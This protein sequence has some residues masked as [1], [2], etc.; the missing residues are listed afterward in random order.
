YTTQ[1]SE[2][3]GR[4]PMTGA[5][6]SCVVVRA[7]VQSAS[8]TQREREGM[9]GFGGWT[10]GTVIAVGVA[11]QAV[12]ARIVARRIVVHLDK[13]RRHA[14]ATPGDHF[15]AVAVIVLVDAAHFRIRQIG[16]VDQDHRLG[17]IAAGELVIG[18]PAG[19]AGTAGT[20]GEV[21]QAV[22]ARITL[23]R[24]EVRERE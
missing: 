4:V 18:G 7:L 2:D 14:P 11:A 24:V 15:P 3:A 13:R 21:A 16:S 17:V 12:V 23:V 9:S 5:Q 8:I 22:A 10:A 20:A 1:L 6:A 19:T